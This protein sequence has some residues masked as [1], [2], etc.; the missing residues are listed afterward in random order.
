[1]AHV[2]GLH[3]YDTPLG[4]AL[5]MAGWSEV[6]FVRLME[7][8]AET[9]PVLLRR[10]AQ[11]LASKEQRANWDDVRRLL[12]TTDPDRADDVRLNIARTYYRTLYA[13]AQEE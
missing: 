9:L 12:F 4:E 2:P 1:M 5:A 6:R 10:M 3:D 7:A 13:Q 8:D 11:Y